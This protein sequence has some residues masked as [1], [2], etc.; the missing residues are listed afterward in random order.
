[1]IITVFV[2]TAASLATIHADT[3]WCASPRPSE[4]LLLDVQFLPARPVG[5]GG[6]DSLYVNLAH[7]PGIRFHRVPKDSVRII[8]DE[9]TCRKVSALYAATI[10]Q[11]VLDRRDAPVLIVRAGPYYFVDD[12]RSRDG[13]SPYWEVQVFDEAWR[14]VYRYGEG[15]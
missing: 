4:P 11:E 14:Y 6:P 13:P 15:D 12:Q 8:Q 1:M 3:T 2:L 10:R 7:L 9:V 5:R